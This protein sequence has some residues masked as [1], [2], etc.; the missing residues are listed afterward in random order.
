MKKEIE[1]K[2][3]KIILRF[4]DW[5]DRLLGKKEREKAEYYRH[6]LRKL[7]VGRI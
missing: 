7:R 1:E 3:K 5:I 2:L 6:A 4:V